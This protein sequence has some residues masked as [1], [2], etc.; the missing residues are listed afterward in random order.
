VKKTLGSLGE[1][2]FI[3][4]LR[5]HKGPR[6]P[7]VALGIGDDAAILRPSKNRELVFTTDMMVE[8][9]HFDLRFCTPWQLGA[10][11]MAVNLSDC[12]AMGAQPKAAVV[13]LGAPRKTSVRFLREFSDGVRSWG[14]QFGCS[15]VGGDTVG[16]DKIVVNVAM[17]GEVEKGRALRRDAA[18]VG[19]VLVVTGNLGDSGAGLHSF[20]NPGRVAHEAVPLLRRRHLLPLPRYTVGRYLVINRIGRCAIDVSDGLSSEVNHLCEESGVG[21]VVHE[22]AIP[23]SQPLRYYCQERRLDSLKFALDGGEDYEIL[24]TVPMKSLT[25]VL[26]EIP[27]QTGT[28]VTPIGRIVPKRQGI[29]SIGLKGKRRPLRPGGF[30]HFS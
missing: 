13:S 16:S 5:S 8:A 12:A 19:D 2:G 1:F 26:R 23:L 21:A 7:F 25:R 28:S 10:K 14:E 9:R 4:T 6:D 24:F 18:Q 3:R 11:A 27:A 15:L 29:T 30:D 22:E 17:L 20:Q